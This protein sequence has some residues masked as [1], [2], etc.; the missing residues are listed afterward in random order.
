[1]VP[2]AND[3]CAFMVS[4][5]IELSILNVFDSVR[6]AVETSSEKNIDDNEIADITHE[7]IRETKL[8]HVSKRSIEQPNSCRDTILKKSKKN[9]QIV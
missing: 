2:I 4:T 3:Y 6:K 9:Q 8:S 1:M 5:M 7:L